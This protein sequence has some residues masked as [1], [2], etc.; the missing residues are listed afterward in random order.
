MVNKKQFYAI[1]VSDLVKKKFENF[2]IKKSS[3][4]GLH[5]SS[6]VALS[7]LIDRENGRSKNRK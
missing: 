2:K 6:D 5:V 1:W 3:K 7:M 4:L